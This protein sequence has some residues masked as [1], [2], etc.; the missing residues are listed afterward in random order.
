MSGS[1]AVTSAPSQK[2]Q[3]LKRLE[4]VPLRKAQEDLY[5]KP[6]ESKFQNL[7]YPLWLD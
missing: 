1:G 5:I 4:L 2:K 3:E 6:P 7:L